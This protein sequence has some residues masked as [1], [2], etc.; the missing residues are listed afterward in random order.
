MYCAITSSNK[1]IYKDRFANLIFVCISWTVGSLLFLSSWAILQGPMNY[2]KHLLSTPR[3]PFT[4]AYFGSIVV[5]LVCSLKVRFIRFFPVFLLVLCFSACP[6]STLHIHFSTGSR[7]L[8]PGAN[9]FL[10]DWGLLGG[11]FFETSLCT[12][13]WLFRELEPISGWFFRLEIEAISSEGWFRYIDT[14]F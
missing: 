9:G 2:T 10:A 12:A 14:E 7:I 3:L 5:T 1:H 4:A 6:D 8:V 11:C 13:G